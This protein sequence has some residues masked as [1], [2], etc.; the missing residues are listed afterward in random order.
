M[1]AARLLPRILAVAALWAYAA[2]AGAEE[3]PEYRLKA[4]FLYNF[5]VFTEW[6][7]EVGTTLNLC[8]LGQDPF[9]AEIDAL[10]D[11]PISGRRIIVQRLASRKSLT[12]C[13]VLF[14]TRSEIPALPAVHEAVGGRPVLTVADSPNAAA[15]GV[16]INMEVRDSKIS[17]E[18]NLRLVQSA[19]LKLSS[20]LLHLAK[21]VYR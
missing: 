6:P 18:V 3:L 19:R 16:A 10:I 9:G 8:I 4:G 15:E 7:A 12:D 1:P 14:I 13:Q 11:R 2:S 20:K 5:M 17:F 21:E